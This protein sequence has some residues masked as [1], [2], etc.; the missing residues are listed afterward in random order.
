MTIF[1]GRMTPEEGYLVGYGAVLNAFQLNLVH[2]L[3]DC[4]IRQKKSNV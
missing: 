3:R 4:L 2:A 1:Y